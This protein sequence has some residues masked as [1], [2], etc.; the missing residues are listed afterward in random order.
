MVLACRRRAI[1]Q[2]RLGS[3]LR[4]TG[5]CFLFLRQILIPQGTN[6]WSN[7]PNDNMG[8]RSVEVRI[9]A[10]A[11]YIKNQA[12]R[13]Q[14]TVDCLLSCEP[15]FQ[16]ANNETSSVWLGRPEISDSSHLQWP[17]TGGQKLTLNAMVAVSLAVS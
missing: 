2:I 5:A 10:I 12:S 15:T 17:F 7:T 6:A 14:Q 3:R 13:I 11:D 1:I 16:W 8:R 4:Y 9:V